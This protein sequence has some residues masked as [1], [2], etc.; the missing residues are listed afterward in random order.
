[1]DID[2]IKK[3]LIDYVEVNS[4]FDLKPQCL[5][6]F[7]T[8]DEH[9]EELFSDGGVYYGMGSNCFRVRNDGKSMST[10][11]EFKHANGEIY[12]K[13]R[14]FMREQLRMNRKNFNELLE[15]VES[16]QHVIDKLCKKIKKYEKIL[17]EF[18]IE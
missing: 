18:G 10:P 8:L 9:G 4:I 13:T 15:V 6:K 11:L 16:Q 7:I 17:E 14:L 12:Y 2:N 1:M 3:R 5:V